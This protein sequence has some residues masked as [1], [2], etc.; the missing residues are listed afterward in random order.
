VSLSPDKKKPSKEK[1]KRPINDFYKY[2]G[3]AIQMGITIAAAVYVGIALDKKLE[4]E[5]PWFTLLLSLIG[6]AAAIYIVIKTT[7]K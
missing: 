3:M 5:T 6:V 4:L 7:T 1:V 2:S